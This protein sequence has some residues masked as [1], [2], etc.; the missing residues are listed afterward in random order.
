MTEIDKKMEEMLSNKDITNIM[1]KASYSFSSQL[2]EDIIYSC[3]LKA[4]W[5][6]I[7]NFKP[8]FKTK[9]TTY[10]YCGVK[11]ECLKE[12]KNHQKHTKNSTRLHTNIPEKRNTD[13][14]MIDVLDEAK[15]EEHLSMLMD[16]ISGLSNQ[17]IASKYG[18][19]R[20][21]LRKRYKKF[22]KTFEHK[23]S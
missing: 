1:H 17:A 16:K 9:F 7:L 14:M 8:K 6:S 21:T 13:L 5:K 15:T 20:E 22:T 10:L 11:Y 2:D 3:K 12:L 18:V 23:F 19:T 4:L